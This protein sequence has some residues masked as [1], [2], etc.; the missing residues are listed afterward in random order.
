[1]P[2]QPV[3]ESLIDVPRDVPRNAVAADPVGSS[4][5]GVE[6]SLKGKRWRLAPVD[7]RVAQ[8]LAQRLHLPEI[9][10]RVLAGRGVALD[11]A[12][13][14][15]DPKLRECMPDP[16]VFKDMEAG[17]ERLVRAVCGGERI[18]VFGDYDVDGATSAAVL[19]RFFRAVG[20]AA[21][22]YVPDRLTEGYGPNTDALLRLKAEGISVVITVDCG[23]N[24][25]DALD[26][27]AAAGLDVVVVDHHVADTRLP[28]AT[29]VI[30]PNRLD[31]PST[32]GH[33]AAVGVAFLLVAAV[34]RALRNRGWYE[35]RPEPDL[36]QWLDLVALG[37]ICDMVPLT[38][39]N[40]AFVAQGLKVMAGRANAGIRALA[41][42][43]GQDQPPG[44][45]HAGF[46]F[47]PRIN[48]GGR[49][50]EAGLGA[51]LLATD[52]PAEAAA[53]ARRLDQF[54]RDRQR[55]E[56]AVLEDAVSR[57]A[58]QVAR[59]GVPALVVVAGEGWHRGVVGI[60]ASRLVE[61]FNRPACVLALDG[62]LATGSARSVAGFDMGAAVNAARLMGLLI[63]AG[64]HAMAAGFTL[65]RHKLA[66]F[67]RFMG[68]RVKRPG[69]DDRPLLYVDGALSVAGASADLSETLAR[70]GPFGTANPE[71]RFVITD[72]R[73]S[74]LA[75]AGADHVRC[76]LVDDS[77]ARLDAIA[78]RC[79]DTPLGRALRDH[80]GAPFHFAGRVQRKIWRGRTMTQLVIDD[81][82]PA[83]S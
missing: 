65:R 78:F 55:I 60:V 44:V 36:R 34:N 69:A 17:A 8:A 2:G 81:A 50:G 70:V 23:I 47:G 39:V 12:A 21:R 37:T 11:G 71:P 25:H 73:V 74:Y 3:D 46:V 26:A 41:D 22:I 75:M 76:V 62:D 82:A 49:V 24:A 53:L 7:E 61:R 15:L 43:T 14:F 80:A 20:S 64:G 32:Y 58:E 10:G 57:V 68:D 38:G 1:M 54:N 27:A 6:Q 35:K 45:Y 66:E 19:E 59:G 16:S 51:R 9:V 72:A 28:A 33:L 67:E 77:G 29:A 13:A 31:E 5:L 40:R 83:M 30:N 42:L 18:A 52:D 56:G 63:K 79:A 48:A 4:F